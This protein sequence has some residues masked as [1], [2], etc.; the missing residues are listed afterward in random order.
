M[1]SKP[2]FL[3]HPFAKRKSGEFPLVSDGN[4]IDEEECVRK[5]VNI[6]LA[7]D[8][9]VVCCIENPEMHLGH[10]HLAEFF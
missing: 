6:K 4:A 1:R 5:P 2:E 8:G 3:L 10:N 7:R 9:N